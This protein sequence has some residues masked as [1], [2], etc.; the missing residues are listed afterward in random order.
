MKVRELEFHLSLM[1]TEGRTPGLHQSS[2]IKAVALRSGFLDWK[3]ALDESMDPLKVILGLGWEDKLPMI[4][5]EMNIEYHPG[6]V[7]QD[8]IIL[9]C[10]GIS[11]LDQDEYTQVWLEPIPGDFTHFRVHEFKL[12][13]KSSRGI[14]GSY[15]FMDSKWWM[16]KAQVMGYCKVWGTRWARLHVYFVNGDYSKGAGGT[17][18]QY[19]I[20]DFEFTWAE[21]NENWKM[22]LNHAHLGTPEE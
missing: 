7:E 14:T 3:W 15:W 16:W 8:G 17:G 2:I 19:R 13:W 10:D 20:F 22:L 12:T 11:E 18:P 6:E 9:T 1:P 5:P 4:H 21:L